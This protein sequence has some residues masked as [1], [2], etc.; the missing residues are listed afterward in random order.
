MIRI[1]CVEVD[2]GAAACVGGPVHTRY[3]TFDVDVP[4]L[5]AWL[6]EPKQQKWTY[7]E[8]NTHGIELLDAEQPEATHA[9]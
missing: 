8:R 1:V 2:A 6:R 5:E 4:A 9:R 7:V 3:R